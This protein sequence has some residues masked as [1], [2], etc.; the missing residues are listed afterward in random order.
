MTIK[1][2]ETEA[3]LGLY[4]ETVT[5]DDLV[6]AHFARRMERERN[7]A[8]EMLRKAVANLSH[9][10]ECLGSLRPNDCQCGYMGLLYV[11]EKMGGSET[12]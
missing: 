5:K 11:V 6:L 3:V 12:K 4:N 9:G 1:T 2:P 10:H 7:E 8:R